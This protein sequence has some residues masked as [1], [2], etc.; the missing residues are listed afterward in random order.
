MV[1]ANSS[2]GM[3][4][5][6]ITATVVG[7]TSVNGGKGNLAGTA[8]GAFMFALLTRSV[9]FFG[10]QDYYSFAFQGLIIIVAVLTTEIKFAS[11]KKWVNSREVAIEA[12][13]TNE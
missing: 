6:F 9:I 8:V 5:T 11:I 4:M 2:Y 3:E 13:S 10:F 7:G 1:Q 12:G